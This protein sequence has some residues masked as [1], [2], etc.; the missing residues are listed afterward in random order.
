MHTSNL[1]VKMSS[2]SAFVIFNYIST[3]HAS[4]NAK[5]I[6]LLHASSHIYLQ[7]IKFK[8]PKFKLTFY[9]IT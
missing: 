2:Y 6:T 5:F 4:L 9:S 3:I 8:M 1:G 7:S